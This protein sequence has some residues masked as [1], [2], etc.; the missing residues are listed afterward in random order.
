MIDQ[1]GRLCASDGFEPDLY[2]QPMHEFDT[3][4][5]YGTIIVCGAFGL[6]GS[7]ADDLA[8]LRR[9]HQHLE[10]GGTLLLDHHL[11]NNDA[12]AWRRWVEPT[13][14]PTDWSRRAD[15]RVAEDGA[16]WSLTSRQFDFDPLEQTTTLEI[17]CTRTLDGETQTEEGQIHINLY[18]K[19]EIELMLETAGFTDI[20]VTTLEGGQPDP[21]ADYRLLFTV[22][23]G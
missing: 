1:C 12:R 19:N 13:Q 20:S 16:E 17:R 18:F 11:P 4:K 15:T 22:N 23:R 10:P 3:G 2:V 8:G 6:G 7:R 14:F 5:K 21:W 9:L